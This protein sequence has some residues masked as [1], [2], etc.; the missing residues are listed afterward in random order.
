M[1]QIPAHLKKKKSQ[2]I[3]QIIACCHH[4]KG[5]EFSQESKQMLPLLF[6]TTVW[7]SWYIDLAIFLKSKTDKRPMLLCAT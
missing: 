6:S 1:D 2:T 4:C 5:A 7:T 3:N